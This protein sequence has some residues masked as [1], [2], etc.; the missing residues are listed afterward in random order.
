M[1]AP[2]CRPGFRTLHIPPWSSKDLQVLRICRSPKLDMGLKR[3]MWVRRYQGQC[4]ALRPLGHQGYR[5]RSYNKDQ[6]LCSGYN[7]FLTWHH[8]KGKKHYTTSIHT[9]LDHTTPPFTALPQD[10]PRNVAHDVPRMCPSMLTRNVTHD[11]P[12]HVPTMCRTM[13]P[14]KCQLMCPMMCPTVC[15]TVNPR[16][17]WDVPHHVPHHVPQDVPHHVVKYL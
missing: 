11:V 1:S 4:R 3:V 12:H 8:T 7:M 14:P 16:C 15:P 10:V 13:C 9:T 2:F 5:L 6:P 17:A